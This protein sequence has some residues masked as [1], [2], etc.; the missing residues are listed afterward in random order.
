M[1]EQTVEKTE[2]KLA[3]KVYTREDVKK[4]LALLSEKSVEPHPPYLH[5]MVLL[6]RMLRLPNAEQLFDSD[7]R[8]QA[9]DIWLK[10]KSMG[11]TIVDP[12]L[13][14]GSGKPAGAEQGTNA[15]VK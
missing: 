6:D 1:S 11:L 10:V 9:R 13:L 8:E 4:V 15:A 12:P 14:F 3:R 7:L 5:A 2:E